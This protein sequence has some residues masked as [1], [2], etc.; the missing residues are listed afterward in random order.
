MSC[1]PLIK[2]RTIQE[3]RDHFKNKYCVFNGPVITFDSIAVYFY[4]DMFDHAFYE[5]S[6][7]RG[8]KDTFSS[9]R[10]ERIDW[11]EFV[12]KDDTAELYVGYN[13]KTKSYGNS[14]RVAIINQDDYVVVIQLT[15]GKRARFITAF[16]ADSPYTAQ[17]IRSGQKWT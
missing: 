11:I 4:E 7:Y 17:K 2:Y 14:R 9:E 3:Y 8:N 12:L 1:P 16:V 10:A 13:N 5:S 6:N 15:H